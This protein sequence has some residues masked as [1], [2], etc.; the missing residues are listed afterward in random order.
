MARQR[1]R[2]ACKAVRVV[3]AWLLLAAKCAY[4][5]TANES[6]LLADA[7]ETNSTNATSPPYEGTAGC[8]RGST[9][10]RGGAD[11]DVSNTHC[12][13]FGPMAGQGRFIYRLVWNDSHNCS[14]V[15]D[16]VELTPS[17]TC[18]L[19][20]VPAM[21]REPLIRRALIALGYNGTNTTNTTNATTTSPLAFKVEA[22]HGSKQSETTGG[23]DEVPYEDERLVE[24]ALEGNVPLLARF[25]AMQFVNTTDELQVSDA[26]DENAGD[27]ATLRDKARPDEVKLPDK[28]RAILANE[29]FAVSTYTSCTETLGVFESVC[30]VER[31]SQCED[32]MSKEKLFPQYNFTFGPPFEREAAYAFDAD[33]GTTANITAASS[34]YH[35]RVRYEPG[36]CYR[37]GASRSV[38]YACASDN[39]RG[40]C[41]RLF[42]VCWS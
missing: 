10:L 32:A 8:L 27:N 1:E 20:Y 39:F 3:V 35:F 14:G 23:G 24:L 2:E 38:R 25:K 40:V 11:E 4:A 29:S 12:T 28:L 17:G 26:D 6:P 7:D 33:W 9:R 30:H 19:R 37:L 21:M 42:P 22:E 36:V 34:A 13:V 5:Q 15:H 31:C 18:R 41:P 16:D